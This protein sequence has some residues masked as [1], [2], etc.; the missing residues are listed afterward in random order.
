M[1]ADEGK[2]LIKL[3]GDEIGGCNARPMRSAPDAA[4]GLQRKRP[5]IVQ[6]FREP[7]SWDVGGTDSPTAATASIRTLLFM[8]GLFN[9]SDAIFSIDISTAFLYVRTY[10]YAVEYVRGRVDTAVR[11][12]IISISSRLLHAYQGGT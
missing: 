9:E 2:R 12:Y 8:H 1:G 4:G 7:L 5:L 10:T 11:K 6:G 3:V